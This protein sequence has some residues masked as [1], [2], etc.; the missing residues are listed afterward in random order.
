[1]ITEGDLI[2]AL[3]QINQINEFNKNVSEMNHTF[4]QMGLIDIYRMFHSA[5]ESTSSAEHGTFC[6]LH[7]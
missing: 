3:S 4:E 2:T 6:R 7:Q 1:M 5:S